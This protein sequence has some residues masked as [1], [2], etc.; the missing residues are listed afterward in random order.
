MV[1]KA[2]VN[3]V[4][5]TI[6]SAVIVLFDQISK[7]MILENLQDGEIVPV[8]DGFFN[9]TLTYNPGIAFGLFA[10]MDP[11]LRSILLSV[12][13]ALALIIVVVLLLKEYRQDRLAHIALAL[14]VGGAVGNI[15][16][17]LRIGS[18]VDFLDFYLGT[19]HWPAFNVADS[20]ICVAVIFLL[21][22]QTLGRSEESP[23]VEPVK[24]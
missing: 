3:W 1:D 7:I 12:T 10:T 6:V 13:I 5:I 15:I 24:D 18:V 23:A 16:D 22:R 2:D 20:A 17:R 11:F 9:L 21:F 4:R 19:Y 8:V 14:V